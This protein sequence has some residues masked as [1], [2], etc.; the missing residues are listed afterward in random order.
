MDVY[1]KSLAKT[2][3]NTQGGF[4]NT[5]WLTPETFGLR[6][7]YAHSQNRY[8]HAYYQNWQYLLLFAL[9]IKDIEAT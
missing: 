5:S 4:N 2:T 8:P 7:P 3:V 1:S 9:A 6:D